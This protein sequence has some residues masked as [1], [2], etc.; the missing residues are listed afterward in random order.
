MGQIL[1]AP[2]PNPRGLSLK[3]FP[4]RVVTHFSS[5]YLGWRSRPL[6]WRYFSVKVV[7]K[8]RASGALVPLFTIENID[9]SNLAPPHIEVTSG[10]ELAYSNASG[11]YRNIGGKVYGIIRVMW[12]YRSLKYKNG[13]LPDDM[14]YLYDEN[15]NGSI[16]E[17]EEL[18][19]IIGDDSFI[20]R[21]PYGSKMA[22]SK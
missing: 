7:L 14:Y 18:K 17:R 4:G 6:R 13:L 8:L 9:L 11:I 12:Y 10:M 20:Q 22:V 16:I 1:V 15:G 19:S 3:G 2:A 5:L 21:F